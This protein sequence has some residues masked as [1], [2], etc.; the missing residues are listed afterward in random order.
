MSLLLRCSFSVHL[1][2]SCIVLWLHCIIV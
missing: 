2:V 1:T